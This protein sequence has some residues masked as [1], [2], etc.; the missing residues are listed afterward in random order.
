MVY[1][2]YYKKFIYLEVNCVKLYQYLY[3]F[4]NLY[5]MIDLDILF[6]IVFKKKKN[7]IIKMYI[8]YFF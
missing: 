6:L 3:Q 5:V 4:V 1:N 8:L 2:Y 7:K